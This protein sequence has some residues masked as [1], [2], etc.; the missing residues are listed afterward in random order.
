L[1]LKKSFSTYSPISLSGLDEV[2]LMDRR[3]E[4]FVVPDF[5]CTDIATQLDSSY[6][7][8]EI[9]GQR[10]FRYDNLYFDTPENIT[11]EDHIRGRKCRYKV[12]IRSY[13]SS[14]LTFLE[15]KKRNIHGR[16]V[17][18]RIKRSND[19][20]W[21]TP[22]TTKE[23][24]F[25]H[26]HVPFANDFQPALY[27]RYTRFTLASI[28]RGERITFDTSLEFTSM[29]GIQVTPLSGLSIVELKQNET[30]RRSPLHKA[31][32]S[33]EDRITPL[34]RGIRVSKY[35]IGRL[36]S[37]E[38]ISCRTYLSSL[39]KLKRATSIAKAQAAN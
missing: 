15:V 18:R 6:K 7:I 28:E 3:E 17:K 37:D 29:S 9:E 8:L 25:I 21:D 4:K 16:S 13:V 30:D 5:W 2:A 39:K 14:N 23:R 27:S 26:K 22:L 20:K 38:S 1:D 24:Q 36:N 12:R 10:S 35:V 31:F 34:G 19:V 32:K 33:R 11:L